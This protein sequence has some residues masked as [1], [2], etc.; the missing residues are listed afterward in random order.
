[1]ET[2]PL[3]PVFD[4]VPGAFPDEQPSHP[5]HL[6]EPD[7]LNA[8]IVGEQPKKDLENVAR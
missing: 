1:M 6:I 4:T 2:E 7:F 5:N 8:V 3:P